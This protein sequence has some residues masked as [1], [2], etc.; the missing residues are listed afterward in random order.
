M[1]SIRKATLADVQSIIILAT[2]IWNE[3]YSNIISKAQIDYMLEARYNEYRIKSEIESEDNVYFMAFSESE[4]VG[5]AHVGLLDEDTSYLHKIYFLSN[6]RGKG[7]GKMILSEVVNFAKTNKS[8]S[9][10]LNVNRANPA[11][12]FYEKMGFE[13]I[14]SVDE[15]I[16]GG[17]FVNDYVMEK[18]IS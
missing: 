18:L 7:L 1:I 13:T 5:F 2:T 14:E 12:G 8:T 17:F 9:L 3:V 6:L 10:V 4:F 11:L 16:G 15:T